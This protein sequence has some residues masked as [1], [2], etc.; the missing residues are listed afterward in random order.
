MLR[1]EPAL[2][3]GLCRAGALRLAFPEAFSWTVEKIEVTDP[4]LVRSWPGSIYRLCLSAPDAVRHSVRFVM[5]ERINE[6]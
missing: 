2:T 6:S 3:P 4:R 5:G 1:E